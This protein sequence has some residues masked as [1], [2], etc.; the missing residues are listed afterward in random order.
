MKVICDAIK[1]GWIE[2]RFGA[3][4]EVFVHGMPGLSVPLRIEDAPE[5]TKSFAVIMDDYD[6]VAVSG[7]NWVHW[8][9]CDL[10]RTE[11]EE[12]ESHRSKDF[13]EGCNSW[14]SIA[15]RNTVEE[16]TGYG[17]PAP[18]DKEHR[19]TLTVY[20]LDTELGLKRGFLLNELH[21]AMMGHILAHDTA[22]GLYSPKD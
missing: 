3:K 17:G 4:G 1:D 11:L 16:A 19:Y 9:L 14:H 15:S 21:F 18:P 20:A 2:D 8:T 5:G 12:G 22:I 6:A 7:F 13:T 10:K